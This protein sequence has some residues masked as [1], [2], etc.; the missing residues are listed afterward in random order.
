MDWCV[1]PI[2]I[3]GS[4]EVWTHRH[5]KN[6]TETPQIQSRNFCP[7]L[8]RPTKHVLG[9]N[10]GDG[11]VRQPPAGDVPRVSRGVR[12]SLSPMNTSSGVCAL[13]APVTIRREDCGERERADARRVGSVPM[14]E[15]E[16]AVP[17]AAEVRDGDG[18]V[19]RVV[20]AVL[21]LDGAGL[22]VV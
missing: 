19:L 2:K 7:D 6:T 20:P 9:D 10:F 11:A 8:K 5:K 17:R 3:E 4:K 1:L 18:G 15:K 16:E 22:S 21:H 13:S 12:T 14:E